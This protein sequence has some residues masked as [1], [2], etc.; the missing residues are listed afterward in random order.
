MH[1]ER[2]DTY[3]TESVFKLLVRAMD[4]GFPIDEE[5]FK[6]LTLKQLED[7]VNDRTDA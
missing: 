7:L 4:K 3:S 2:T 1:D 6:S 5:W